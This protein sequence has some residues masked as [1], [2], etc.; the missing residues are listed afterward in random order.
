MWFAEHHLLEAPVAAP[1]AASLISGV[2]SRRHRAE[3]ANFEFRKQ[4]MVLGSK[5]DPCYPH[6]SSCRRFCTSLVSGGAA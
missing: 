3:E 2:K 6:G 4:A 1:A 5:F